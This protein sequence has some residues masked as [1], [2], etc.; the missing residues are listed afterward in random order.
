MT[1][2]PGSALASDAGVP[3]LPFRLARA[4]TLKL[5]K[6]R[7]L[8][9]VV[10]LLTIGVICVAFVAFELFH[11]SNSVKY[12]PAG[13]LDHFQ[14][15]VF[16]LSQLGSVAAALLGATAGAGDLGAGVFRELVV[17]GRSRLALYGARI[18]GA[19][20]VLWPLI[21]VAFTIISIF[22]VGLA[23]GLPT[24]SIR[25]FVESGLWLELTTS[26]AFVLGLGLASL[27]GSRAT[28]IAVLFGW[29]IVV[30]PILA[31]V[32]PLGRARDALLNAGLDRIAPHGIVDRDLRLPMSLGIAVVVVA[33]WGVA[34]LAAG[35][36]RTA[37]RDA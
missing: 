20:A 1:T 6:R 34:A 3:R 15:A 9:T 24:P 18:P 35:A 5:R 23:D 7:G 21:A 32:K 4:E 19:L 31:H 33:T 26:L 8:M 2:L 17:T 11:V 27:I 36:W 22:T 13:G 29:I 25:L 16:I 10:G 28:T 30:E 14:H 37:T 12:G